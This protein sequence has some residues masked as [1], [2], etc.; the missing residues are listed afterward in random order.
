MIISQHGLGD[1]DYSSG[2]TI[3]PSIFDS[4]NQ[5]AISTP[6]I[7]AGDS[8]GNFGWAN[9]WTGLLSGGM[10]NIATPILNSQF[11]GPKPGQYFASTPQGNIAYALPQG[12]SGGIVNPFGSSIG[13]GGISGFLPLLIIGGIG[14]V[15]VKMI[16]K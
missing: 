13:S 14:L 6:G 3:Q 12:S 11:G 9:F 16:S 7:V 8:S 1:V 4:F 10:K 2:E 15:V 5:Q